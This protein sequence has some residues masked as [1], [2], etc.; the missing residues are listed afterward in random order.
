MHIN[1][2]KY[3]FNLKSNISFR[4]VY[5]LI[6]SIAENIKLIKFDFNR[7]TYLDDIIKSIDFIELN[8]SDDKDVIKKYY[9]FIYYT[10]VNIVFHDLKSHFITYGNSL[11]HKHYH[12]N[13]KIRESILSKLNEL[14]ANA[15]DVEK[16]TLSIAK[17]QLNFMQEVDKRATVQVL[18]CFTLDNQYFIETHYLFIT[19]YEILLKALNDV[20]S[21]KE[22]IQGKE[23]L[24]DVF[25]GS[26]GQ[27]LL[28]KKSAIFSQGTINV[29]YF[30][31]I[32]SH[33]TE[34]KIISAEFKKEIRSQCVQLESDR[35]LKSYFAQIQTSL[36]L[37]YDGLELENKS[38]NYPANITYDSSIPGIQ[39]LIRSIAVQRGF[40]I[41]GDIIISENKFNKNS[42]IK[43]DLSPKQKENLTDVCNHLTENGLIDEIKPQKFKSVLISP[44]TK[45]SI[46]WIGTLTSLNYFVKEFGEN[47]TNKRLRWEAATNIFTFRG[48]KLDKKVLQNTNKGASKKDK[49]NIDK[50][51]RQITN[52]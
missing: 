25:F 28:H 4:N 23:A 47:V 50:A 29:E 16:P 21:I 31:S 38:K 26:H 40:N 2:S 5:N 51:V 45:E 35:K 22:A 27:L 41:P 52:H 18:E 19:Q 48:D 7:Y 24:H 6:D 20:I 1:Q 14:K 12:V 8:E 3:P 13:V 39:N 49:A 10:L 15:T 37:V 32:S 33:E 36:N 46:N 11:I 9:N 17:L 44:N 30:N 34:H 42:D 43:Y